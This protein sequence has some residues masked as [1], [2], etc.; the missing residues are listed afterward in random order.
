MSIRKREEYEYQSSSFALLDDDEKC[1]QIQDRWKDI[2][3]VLSSSDISL[4][5]LFSIMNK[6]QLFCS[7]Y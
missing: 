6:K 2:M 5:F 7:L 3:N 4:G 1:F